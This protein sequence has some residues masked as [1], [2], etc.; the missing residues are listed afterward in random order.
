MQK[1]NI[2]YLWYMLNAYKTTEM[3][4]IQATTNL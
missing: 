1:A 3:Q 2:A 4:V